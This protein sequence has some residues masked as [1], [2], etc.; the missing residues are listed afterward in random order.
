MSLSLGHAE[1]I[2]SF[3]QYNWQW[4]LLAKNV[5]LGL[6][7]PSIL[8]PKKLMRVSFKICCCLSVVDSLT[9]I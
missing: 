7:L 8:F 3:D 2:C 5:V 6:T 1:A 4:F 9:M